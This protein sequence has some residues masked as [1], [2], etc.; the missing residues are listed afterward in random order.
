MGGAFDRAERCGT[1]GVI[2]EEH[3]D[4][5]DHRPLVV[6]GRLLAAARRKVQGGNRFGP[7][8]DVTAF[9]HPDN[10]A[11]VERVARVVGAVTR[12]SSRR[13]SAWPRRK[14]EQ[15]RARRHTGR[16][17]RCVLPAASRASRYNSGVTPK[18]RPRGKAPGC[19]AH[20]TVNAVA[21][22]TRS[23]SAGRSGSPNRSQRRAISGHCPADSLFPTSSAMRIVCHWIA[24]ATQVGCSLTCILVRDDDV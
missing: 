9:V 15:M 4:G 12:A 5:D 17:P 3:I 24:W 7:I 10:R 11:L 21:I 2:V 8:E 1:G 18:I 6:N 22:G 19:L 20:Q 16:C 13:R 14:V 23:S